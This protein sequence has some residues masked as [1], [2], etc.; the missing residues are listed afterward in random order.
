MTYY[1]IASHILMCITQK[2]YT[3]LKNPNVWI[4]L[5]IYPLRFYNLKHKMWL[6]N[7]KWI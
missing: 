4:R 6:E 1:S 5:K 2:I 3:G 7:L